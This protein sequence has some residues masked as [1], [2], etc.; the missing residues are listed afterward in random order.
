M[1]AAWRCCVRRLPGAK[2]RF[3]PQLAA[4]KAV[5]DCIKQLLCR[6]LQLEPHPLLHLVATPSC[7]N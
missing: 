7:R 2:G 5:R 6:Q 1:W 3:L 4:T